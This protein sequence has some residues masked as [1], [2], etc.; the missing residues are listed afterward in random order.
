MSQKGVPPPP[1]IPVP[2][3]H[4]G[5]KKVIFAY[6]LVCPYAYV[7]SVLIE[8]LAHEYGTKLEFL[9]GQQ[10]LSPHLLHTVLHYHHR[11]LISIPLIS[12]SSFL[13]FSPSLWPEDDGQGV[14][15]D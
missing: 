13:F 3:I 15:R 9:P 11:T 8:E 4:T 5:E 7:A 14:T 1:A 2:H 12:P 6:D 10:P